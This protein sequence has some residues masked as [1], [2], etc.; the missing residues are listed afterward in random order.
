MPD[1]VPFARIHCK[2]PGTRRC[3]FAGIF[4]PVP[5]C[6]C[7]H[8]ITSKR[9]WSRG[10]TIP[11][12]TTGQRRREGPVVVFLETTRGYRHERMHGVFRAHG[13]RSL[14]PCPPAPH[15]YVAAH[16]ICAFDTKWTVT[17]SRSRYCRQR[18]YGRYQITVSSLQHYYNKLEAKS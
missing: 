4:W 8:A 13:I 14:P 1:T 5:M 6:M 16:S 10:C 9:S 2:S 15:G 7:R 17:K 12:T 18:D 3:G 11:A